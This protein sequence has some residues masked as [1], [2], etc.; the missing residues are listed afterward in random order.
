MPIINMRQWL[1]ANERLRVLPTDKWYLDFAIKIA[2]IIKESSL[3]KNED[4]DIQ[5]SAAI[6]LALYLQDAISQSGG[7]K[8][9]SELFFELY[10]TYLPFYPLTDEYIADE[11]NKEDIAFILWTLKSQTIYGDYCKYTLCDPFNKDLL[12][13]SQIVYDL[14]DESF[15]DAPIAEEPSSVFWVMEIDSLEIPATPL[16]ETTPEAVLN[17]DASLS[18]EYSHGRPL[19][20]F[21]TYQEL[22]TFFIEV[23][24]WENNP[25]S[26][27]SDLKYKKEFV[28]YANTKGILIAHNV[29]AYFCDEHNPMYDARRAADEG[30]KMFCDPGACPFDLLKYGMAKGMLPDIQLPFPNGK[31][32]LHQNWDFLSRYYLFDYYEGE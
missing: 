16:P 19:L 10:D 1:E 13:L 28:V 29:A 23:L 30:Y 9:F 18:L 24:K 26:L 5:A 6:S 21:A 12:A 22:R 11:I 17:K 25:N 4:G 20:Y 3:F 14:M 15:E 31:E 27:I 8:S 2:P 32:L 7:W